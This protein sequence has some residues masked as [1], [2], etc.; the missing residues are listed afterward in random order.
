MFSKLS[1]QIPTTLTVNFSTM[2]VCI[3]QAQVYAIFDMYK[4]C[5][6]SS[7]QAILTDNDDANHERSP[8]LD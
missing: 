7:D 4:V 6:Q 8:G 3:L 2:T 5:L 1:I